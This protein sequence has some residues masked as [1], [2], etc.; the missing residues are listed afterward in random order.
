MKEFN[1]V[2]GYKDVKVELERIVDMMVNPDKYRDLG[3]RTTR[4]LLLYGEPGVGKTLMAKCLLKASKRKSFTVRKD[5]PDGDFVKLIKSTFDKAKDEAPSI[6]FL[7]DIDKFANEDKHHKNA[8]EFVTIQSCIDDCKDDEV[9][10]IATANE[11]ECLPNSLLREGRFDK[12]IEIE[13]PKGKD[14]EDIIKYYLSSKKIDKNLDYKEIARFL[15]GKS[16]AS[17]ETVINEAG[18]YAAYENKKCIDMDDIIRA[19]MRV[20]YDAPEAVKNEDS[21]YLR[22]IAVHEAGHTVIGEVLEPESVNIVTVKKHSSSIGGF[23]SYEQDK[24]YFMSKHFMENRV[25]SLLG[26]KAAVELVYGVT[27]VGCNNDLHRAFDITERFV[28]DYCGYGFNY[29]EGIGRKS[30]DNLMERKENFIQNEIERYF[31]MAKKILIEN[32]EFLDKLADSLV[33]KKTLVYQDIQA[34]KKTCKK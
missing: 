22:Q 29:W 8:E 18:V 26:G 34:I 11:L 1:R 2:I 5:A 6:V 33:D 27:D 21:K 31:Q 3:V 32:R 4:G 13:A 16:C 30:S 17:L 10:V 20:V 19:F 23:T 28:D 12:N 7:D 14:A 25:M 9:F 15:N 24:D